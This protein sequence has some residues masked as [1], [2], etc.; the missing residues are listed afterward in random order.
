[1][2]QIENEIG[3][4]KSDRDYSL[5]ANQAFQEKIPFEIQALYN[6]TGTWKETFGADA[7]EYFMAWCYAKAIEEIASEGKKIYPL[8][9]YVNAWLEQH[10]DR[11]GIYPSGGPVAKLIPLWKKG[12]P[13][14]DMISPDIYVRDFKKE[15]I[16]Y[17]QHGNPLFIPETARNAKSASR[18]FYAVGAHRILGFV[19]FGIEDIQN[20]NKICLKKDQLEGLNIME[21]AFDDRNTVPY[22]N[23]SYRLLQAMKEKIFSAGKDEIVGYIRENTNE[24]GCILEFENFDLQLDYMYGETGSAG[25]IFPEKDGFYLVG[26]NTRFT[27][28]PKKGRYEN[29][30]IVRYEEG[31]FLAEK[32]IRKRILN[33]DERYDMA[34]YNM[35][36][37]K[38]VK[39]L[40]PK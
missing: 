32:W 14:I 34:V 9:M 29:V 27:V 21:E 13:S 4:L 12:A 2:V 39:L 38:Y 11:A 28:L 5:I 19:P 7:E 31:E 37:G 33:G 17:A 23:E 16:A 40:I 18:I 10:P 30:E 24:Q 26:C 8:P 1:M 36:Q 35:P 22:L 25:I 20:Q 6:K 3:F 15:C